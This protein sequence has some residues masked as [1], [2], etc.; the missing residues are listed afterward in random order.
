MGRRGLGGLAGLVLVALVVAAVAGAGS[1]MF[2]KPTKYLIRP[3]AR[4]RRSM[5]YPAGQ[6]GRLIPAPGRPG[7]SAKATSKWSAVVTWRISR[8]APAKCKTTMLAISLGNYAHWLPTTK[9]I[10]PDG[11]YSGTVRLS[12]SSTELPSDTVIGEANGPPKNAGDS[13]P[14]GVSIRR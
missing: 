10:H 6:P 8:S 9:V 4:C 11:R 2:T 3:Q 12:V 7:L 13:G 1:T 14:A 5:F